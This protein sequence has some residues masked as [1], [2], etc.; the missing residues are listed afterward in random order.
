M[1]GVIR[2][3]Q[4]VQPLFLP[5]CICE[6]LLASAIPFVNLF[7]GK[8]I[9]DGVA[10]AVSLHAQGKILQAQM[11]QSGM[12]KLA[13]LLVLVNMVMALVRWGIDK[14]VIIL[15]RGIEAG[16]LNG[17]AV[18]CLT[19]DY[20]VLERAETL[21]LVTKA[22][23][24]VNSS[25][26]IANYCI[27]FANIICNTINIVYGIAVFSTFILRFSL[28]GVILLVMLC[29][30]FLLQF[31]LSQRIN[32]QQYRFY[33]ANVKS[34]RRFSAFFQLIL[35]YTA[36]KQ[37]RIF[38]LND[39][40]F[41][42]MDKYREECWTNQD[43]TYR[44]TLWLNV[45]N[46]VLA[47]AGMMAYYFFVGYR[48]VTGEI[49]VGEMTLYIGTLTTIFG[50]GAS[51]FW[52]YSRLLVQEA[53]LGNY[54]ELMQ[55][56]NEK[57]KGTLPVEKRL[58]NDYELEFCNVSFHYP[59]SDKLVLKNVTKKLHVGGKLAI[60]GKNGSG[61]STFIKLLC[62]LY[63]PTEGEILLNGIDIRKYDYDEYRSLFGVVFQD[64]HLFPFSVAQNVAADVSY[65]GE[66]V[67]NALEKS[68]MAERVKAMAKGMD[69][70]IDRSEEDG[71][72]LS[73]GEAQKV[74]IARAL[75]KDAPVVILDEPTA[76]L[77]PVS[78]L[79]IYERFDEMVEEKT[80]IYISHRMS[81]CRFCENVIVFDDGNIV[82]QGKHEELLEEE[83]MYARLWKAQA[84][85]YTS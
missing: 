20:Q 71:I 47:G 41:R 40:I 62:R 6:Q 12:V 7:L 65:D 60:V 84:Q 26:S 13:L 33:E 18:K 57:Y 67:E 31:C 79:E 34:N 39:V 25:G 76:A 35:Y 46:Q 15:R 73:G 5:M 69:T 11:A 1:R 72:E 22:Q 61:K 59:N 66:L 77:D 9:V 85:Y 83:G 28:S 37:I 4:Q 49:S 14:Y 32:M 27:G 63:D 30:M 21:D 53:Y 64:F 24:G 78:E 16:I 82:Q 44:K 42:H 58:D 56:K 2:M 55:L 10:D 23:E 54:S 38:H 45:L 74:A 81:S 48:A 52:T 51:I 29:M 36:G 8:Q 50:S 75:Y 17:V 43:H 80:A 3:V 68:G 19:M 70:V